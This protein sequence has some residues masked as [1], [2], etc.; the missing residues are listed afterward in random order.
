MI[1]AEAAL[2][3]DMEAGRRALVAALRDT[4]LRIAVAE[5][6]T[7]GQ[8]A[9][10]LARD[11]YLGPHLDR[12]FIV[13]SA[14]SK[15]ELLGVARVDVARCE[16]VNPEVAEGLARGALAR[17]DADLAIGITGFCGP[18]QDEEEVGLVYL[19]GAARAGAFRAQECHF[20]AIGRERVLDMAVAAGLTLL[21]DL[22]RGLRVPVFGANAE[23]GKR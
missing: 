10:L 9:S 2:M 13:Y 16:A 15:H 17:S 21:A 7:G 1:I 14:H 19:A 23:G 4:E 18:Q 20:G 3:H 5:S 8:L 6:C 11:I 22:A 12:G